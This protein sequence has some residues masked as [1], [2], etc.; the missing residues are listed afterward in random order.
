MKNLKLNQLSKQKVTES[1]MN[2]IKGGAMPRP[3]LEAQY[4][5]HDCSNSC[6]SD[7]T[8]EGLNDFMSDFAS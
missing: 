1:E 8:S 3:F 7:V 5:T 6:K 2:A 4:A